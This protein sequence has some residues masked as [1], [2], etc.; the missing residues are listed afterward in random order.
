MIYESGD[1]VWH[2]VAKVTFW[3]LELIFVCR[4][5]H[6][7]VKPDL[8]SLRLSRRRARR[9]EESS[10]TASLCVMPRKQAWGG[11]SA[12]P[13]RGGFPS[14]K[15]SPGTAKRGRRKRGRGS[16]ATSSSSSG[17]GWNSGGA[18]TDRGI[19]Q[20]NSLAD[21]YCPHTHTHKFAGHFK[22]VRRNEEME[23]RRRLAE[24]NK[25]AR[26]VHSHRLERLQATQGD[27]P[28]VADMVLGQ[29]FGPGASQ[30]ET[31]LMQRSAPTPYAGEPLS[32][33]Q[34]QELNLGESGPGPQQ[35][36][37]RPNGGVTFQRAQ[38]TDP[39]T[40]LEVLKTI[41][42]REGYL[43]RLQHAARR[44]GGSTA[45]R[46][47][48]IDILDLIRTST[49]EVVESIAKWRRTLIKPYPF[50]WNGINYLLKIPSDLDMLNKVP[51]VEA[52]LGFSLARNPFVVPVGLDDRPGTAEVVGALSSSLSSRSGG[53]ATASTPGTQS[54][55]LSS[56][57]GSSTRGSMH[58]ST[59]GS[60]GKGQQFHEI[61]SSE[62][63]D[64]IRAQQIARGDQAAVERQAKRDAAGGATKGKIGQPYNTSVVNDPELTGMQ[65]AQGAAKSLAE[66]RR[67]AA[68]QQAAAEERPFPSSVGDV[69]MLRIRE[70]EKTLLEEEELHGR[71]MRD[72]YGRLVPEA[73]RIAQDA[74]KIAAGDFTHPDDAEYE[75]SSP[76]RRRK[77][78]DSRPQ[79]GSITLKV[80][81]KGD[82]LEDEGVD[83]QTPLSLEKGMP[84][85]KKRA[86][87]DGGSLTPLS[88]KQ[89]R[90]R[91][92]KPRTGRARAARL[93][94]DI[95][96][97]HAAGIELA[98]ELESAKKELAALEAEVKKMEDAEAA[99]SAATTI[100][101]GARGRRARLEVERKRLKLIQ[102]QQEVERREK[103]L[104]EHHL[105]MQNKEAA[106]ED[107][108][109]KRLAQQQDRREALLERK[110][111]ERND[112]DPARA[113]IIVPDLPEAVEDTSAIQIQRIARGKLGKNFVKRRRRRYHASATRIQAGFRGRRSRLDVRR[114]IKEKDAATHIQRTIRGLLGRH[115]AE[116]VRRARQQQFAATDM[117]R[118]FRAMKGRRRMQ[119]KRDLKRYASEAKLAIE[120]LFASDLAE[121]SYVEQ[122]KPIVVAL[123]T[124]IRIL[125]PAGQGPPQPAGADCY[126]WERVRRRMRRPHFLPR[127]RNLADAA[128]AE[129]L[130]IPTRRV[131]AIKVY[132]DDPDFHTDSFR[133]VGQGT[134]AATS[135]H[136]FLR[137]LI[138]AEERI[139]IFLP[140]SPTAGLAWREAELERLDSESSGDE[141]LEKEF[142]QVSF[143]FIL[144]S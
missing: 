78:G 1:V 11:G 37:S 7:H 35:S 120:S 143:V 113:N 101:A 93:D 2:S 74:R 105:E 129:V 53:L 136:I 71:M 28:Y 61:G 27:R 4:K 127:L 6:H 39:A 106:R 109:K 87:R 144:S 76:K 42:L 85:G 86:L 72:E 100:Q 13:K 75:A 54:M 119:A 9:G 3:L 14:V 89:T 117:Q 12:S 122:P 30:N 140:G 62:P 23:R 59:R 132:Y 91:T 111:A 10:A 79:A 49:V 20:Y 121:L 18:V 126:R 92:N 138:E 31:E 80:R 45:L 102:Q 90:G 96:R 48:V 50:V 32:V 36:M 135:L 112:R 33:D 56:T 34:T 26:L 16:S 19:P 5:N 108:R 88:R 25:R 46:S 64:F 82:D 69:D 43:K 104:A 15:G 110:M 51:E 81:R 139:K 97:G 29:D 40:E 83:L 68:Q 41:L 84:R 17:G 8:L 128:M 58:G 99:E 133:L 123:M 57:T 131:R 116:R 141:V 94:M 77:F 124:C 63:M 98:D 95:K 142:I 115:K 107:Y 52:W 70:A 24:N 67:R 66:T 22:S 118:I 114:R 137:A 134:K 60:Q 130:Q 38:S 44:R 73:L 21:R 125:W 55:S 103:E 47:D 65:A